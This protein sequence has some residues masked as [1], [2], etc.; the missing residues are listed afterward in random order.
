MATATLTVRVNLISTDGNTRLPAPVARVT[1]FRPP[2]S[3]VRPHE[4]V[5][6]SVTGRFR[7]TTP[8]KEQGLVYLNLPYSA[9][10]IQYIVKARSTGVEAEAS[11]NFTG[12]ANLIMDLATVGAEIGTPAGVDVYVRDSQSQPVQGALVS[13]RQSGVLVAQNYTNSSGAAIFVVNS[14]DY[15][16]F[17]GSHNSNSTV[18]GHYILDDGVIVNLTVG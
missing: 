18:Q 1:V 9:T 16:D 12:A 2:T 15:F 13:V 8:G 10:G 14:P 17:H 3:A 5:A 7:N 4:I 6:T 11:I